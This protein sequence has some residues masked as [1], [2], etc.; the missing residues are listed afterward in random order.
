MATKIDIEEH[1][2]RTRLSMLQIGDSF[3]YCGELFMMRGPNTKA[4]GGVLKETGR[5]LVNALSSG[6]SRVFEGDYIVEPVDIE[7]KV[8]RK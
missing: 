7:I 2:S 6:Y 1:R 8:V 5:F 4:V 3:L